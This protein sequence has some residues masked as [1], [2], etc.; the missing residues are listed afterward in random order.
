M[1]QTKALRAKP[2]KRLSASKARRGKPFGLTEEDSETEASGILEKVA[3]LSI[4]TAKERKNIA[5]KPR[6]GKAAMPERDFTIFPAIGA[7]TMEAAIIATLRLPK[8]LALAEVGTR[9]ATIEVQAG[10]QKFPMD[11]LR[12]LRQTRLMTAVPE[13]PA[14]KGASDMARRPSRPKPPP[15][16]T[17]RRLR[18]LIREM[19]MTP[20]NIAAAP[21]RLPRSLSGLRP[22]NLQL[23]MGKIESGNGTPIQTR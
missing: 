22:P 5:W 9:S 12:A 8:C 6:W 11:I 23:L 13:S 10:L 21:Q 18:E 1:F 17:T 20:G 4:P 2:A 14:R 3:V 19:A 15:V 16:R 7:A